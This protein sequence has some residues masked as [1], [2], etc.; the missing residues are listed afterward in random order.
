VPWDL[1]PHIPRVL[2]E[3][4]IVTTGYPHQIA[5]PG[6]IRSKRSRHGNTPKTNPS[7]Q[8]FFLVFP[9]FF[10]KTR[11]D[12]VPQIPCTNAILP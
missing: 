6:S 10:G 3:R 9:S 8:R 7:W 4:R 1:P 2:K 11:P 12:V 5:A